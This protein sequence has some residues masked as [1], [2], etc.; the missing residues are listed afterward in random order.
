MKKTYQ[1]SCHCG[2]VRFEAD[3]DK[4]AGARRCHCWICARQRA[5][6]TQVKLEDFRLLAGESELGDYQCDT[7]SGHPLFCRT[8]GVASFGRGYVDA[9]GGEYVSIATDCL[10]DARSALTRQLGTKAPLAAAR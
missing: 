7:R 5:W 10:D 8:C 3:I 2:K 4:D 9:K 1:G 6:A